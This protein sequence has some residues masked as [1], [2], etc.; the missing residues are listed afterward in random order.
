MAM[1]AHRASVAPPPETETKSGFPKVYRNEEG[2]APNIRHNF[3]DWEGPR[4]SKGKEDYHEYPVAPSPRQAF[5]YNEKSAPARKVEARVHHNDRKRVVEEKY[6]DPG[7]I[8][9]IITEDQN[10]TVGALYHPDGNLKAY[11]RAT[12]QPLDR[13]GRAIVRQYEQLQIRPSH[14]WDQVYHG[15]S[16]PMDETRERKTRAKR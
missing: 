14:T 5:N 2:R 15:G 4:R 8:R 6:N 1:A 16:Y 10:R 9:A 7:A 11:E 3:E 12:L 13:H